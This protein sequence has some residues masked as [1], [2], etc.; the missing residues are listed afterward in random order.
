MTLPL[1]RTVQDNQL[2]SEAWPAVRLRVAD[3]F[4]YAGGQR[5][6][7]SGAADAEQHLFVAAGPGNA[8]RAVLW[9]QFEQF[10]EGSPNTYT[11]AAK[12]TVMR[13]G[14]AFLVDG[15]V[16]DWDTDA[17][18]RPDSDSARA[19]AFLRQRGYGLRTDSLYVRLVCVPDETRRH[20]LMLIYAEDLPGGLR[21]ADLEPGGPQAAAWPG[22]EAELRE[23]A[24]KSL[25]VIGGA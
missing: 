11:Y 12:E 13:G 19:G 4:A 24:L 7:L 21:V 22:L 23:R 17:V 8:A 9:A 2:R 6:I 25:S 16:H 10:L 15:G 1:Q 3:T 5:F 14:L 18:Q 20:E